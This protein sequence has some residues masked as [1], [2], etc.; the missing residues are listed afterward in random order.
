MKGKDIALYETS[1]GGDL[2]ISNND[3]G[4]TETL[5]HQIYIS[6]FG[7]NVEASTKG[8]ELS[9]EKRYDWWG[10]SLIFGDRQEKQF[11]SETERVL[12]N[13][14]LNSAGRLEIEQSVKNDLKFLQ[15]VV[16]MKINI[17]I[18]NQNRVNI[19]VQFQELKNKEDKILQ[20]AWDNSKKEVII[21]KLI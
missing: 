16:D 14:V 1:D 21:Q 4:S 13:T 7:G 15:N 6:L 3:L 17:Q 2:F 10:N 20:F 18:V 12:N 5:I 8:N 9:S 11:N 19:L